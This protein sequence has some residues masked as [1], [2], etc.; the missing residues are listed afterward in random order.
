V[1]NETEKNNI[2]NNLPVYKYEGV[3]FY[4][5]ETQVTDS[6]PVYR[7]FNTQNGA[8][9]YTDSD[10]EKNTIISTL[11]KFSFEGTKFYVLN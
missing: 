7:F 10:A 6:K 11:P 3:K 2:M 8:H 4:V 5:Y 1:T 9:L